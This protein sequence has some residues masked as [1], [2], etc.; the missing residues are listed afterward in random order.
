M[1]CPK[2]KGRMYTEKYFDYVR[3]YQGWKCSC[4]GEMLD[5]TII[6]NRARNHN[7]YLG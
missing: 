7:H 3:S 1:K 6:S 5:P 2:C 4:C